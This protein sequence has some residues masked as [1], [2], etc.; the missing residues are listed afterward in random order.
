MKKKLILPAIAILTVAGLTAGVVSASAH[1]MG[2]NDPEFSK[3]L[4]QKLGVSE[5][6]VTKAFD[7]LHQE[8][9]TKMKADL[10]SRLTQAVKDG[11]ITDAQ[12]N[13]IQERFG[14]AQIKKFDRKEFDPSQMKTE[15]EKRK[16]ELENW[17]KENNISLSTLR[18][19]LRP[20][21]KGNKMHHMMW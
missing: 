5:D 20:Q 9:A 8:K 16:T 1:F 2:K 13:A 15:M 7:E 18:E 21:G 14:E 10:E 19:L 12:K 11:K 3:T 4:A 17:A 6:K